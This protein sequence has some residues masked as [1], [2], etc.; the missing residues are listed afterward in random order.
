MFRPKPGSEEQL[1]CNVV[2]YLKWKQSNG[3]K[4]VYFHVPNE[5]KLT[6]KQG[7]KANRLGRVKGAPD[8]VIATDNGVSFIELKK[9]Y[10]SK[11]SPAQKCMMKRCKEIN[12]P[13]E[14]VHSLDELDAA[15]S[16]LSNHSTRG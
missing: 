16:R 5:R 15:L 12:M 10:Q 7:R 11:L 2:G 1:A 3:E 13:Y 14:V 6:P 4:I 9:D 8:F